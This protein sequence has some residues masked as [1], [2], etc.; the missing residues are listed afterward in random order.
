MLQHVWAMLAHRLSY[1]SDL[2]TPPYWQRQFALLAAELENAEDAMAR[3]E[4][5][6]QLYASGQRCYQDADEITSEIARLRIVLRSDPQ[7]VKLA[8]RIA[9]LASSIADWDMVVGV[10]TPFAADGRSADQPTLLTQLGHALFKRQEDAPDSESLRRSQ[11]Y[12]ERAG[13]PDSMALSYLADTWRGR[14]ERKAGNLYRQAFELDPANYHA[15]VKYLEHEIART[16]SASVLPLYRP[17]MT[18]ALKRCQKEADMGINS[19]WPLYG[20]AHLQLLR[21]EPDERLKTYCRAIRA[22]TAPFMIEDEIARIGRLFGASD[23][24]DA[25]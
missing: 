12:L 14:D 3:M 7:N 25:S 15:L 11:D 22:S 17:V 21:G 1:K 9:S 19:P 18:A 20:M 13:Q 8:C 16:S 23:A 4:E 6:L 10:L 5:G 24:H 2:E